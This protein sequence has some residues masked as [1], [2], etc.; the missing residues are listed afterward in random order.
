MVKVSLGWRHNG[1]FL[2]KVCNYF[3]NIVFTPFSPYYFL[4][5]FTLR[6]LKTGRL[7]LSYT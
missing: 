6:P 7:V 1:G 5:F 2:A 4:S 3:N